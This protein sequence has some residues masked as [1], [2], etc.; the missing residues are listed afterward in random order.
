MQHHY[1]ADVW[2]AP[3]DREHISTLELRAVHLTLELLAAKLTNKAVRIFCD[4]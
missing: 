4:N 2:H 3:L 1:L